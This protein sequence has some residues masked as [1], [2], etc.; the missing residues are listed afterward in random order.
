MS[1]RPRPPRRAP[2]RS[3]QGRGVGPRGPDPRGA[4]RRGPDPRGADRRGP[5]PR[6]PD[7]RGP[8]PRGP[9]PRGVDPRAK[10]R[11][12]FSQASAPGRIERGGDPGL[13]DALA[14]ALAAAQSEPDAAESFTHPF[15]TYPA[16]MHPATARRLL[17]LAG[18]RGGPPAVLDPF[19]GSGT[20][21]VEARRI[22]ASAL[23]SDLNPLAVAIARAK[24]WTVPLPQR[25]RA[26]A[27]GREVVAAALAEVKAA[28]RAGHERAPL[29]R[30]GRNPGARNHLLGEWFAPHV[31]RELET[32][33]ELI[34]DVGQRDGEA[35]D[36]LRV[37]LSSVLYKVSQRSSDTDPRRVTRQIARGA[38]ARL[39][40]GRLRLLFEGLDELAT[41]ARGQPPRV[42]CTDAR[43]LGGH[44]PPESFDIAVTSPPYAG[45]YDYA[46]QH[47]MRM[48]F[49]G[50][51]PGD[52]ARGEIGA[53][54]RFTGSGGQREQA[55]DDTRAALGAALG[56]IARA[57]VPGG[58]AW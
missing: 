54:A 51:D 23:G 21:L 58:R 50:M 35:A 52:F 56:Q 8:D 32:L 1:S 26:W 7:R 4:D 44:A 2:T 33:G 48:V 15:H 12:S 10:Q 13:A 53:R 31:R 9:D 45:T 6:G 14:D 37:A 16:R 11:R 55:M 5:D 36:V 27:I 18:S 3:P 49:L 46:D 41:A 17:A 19:C 43:R 34:D 28:R 22:G 30:V 24:T 57:L 38:A 42:V 47:R 20:T 25:K 40:D 29:R 39:F